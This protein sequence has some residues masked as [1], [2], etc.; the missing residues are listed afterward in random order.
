[1]KKHAASLFAEWHDA[2]RQICILRERQ[3][4]LI[5]DMRDRQY[6][7]ILKKGR[8]RPVEVVVVDLSTAERVKIRRLDTGKTYWVGFYFL[9]NSGGLKE[10]WQSGLE[11]RLKA[12]ITNPVAG[13]LLASLLKPVAQ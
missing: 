11:D 4:A 3:R 9:S 6:L 2:E 8:M 10:A 13:G 12:Q 7:L 5:M 1:V